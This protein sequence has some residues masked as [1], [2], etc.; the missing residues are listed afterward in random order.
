MSRYRSEPPQEPV[1]MATAPA[2]NFHRSPSRSQSDSWRLFCWLNNPD[3]SGQNLRFGGDGR[4]S[5]IGCEV[6]K[7]EAWFSEFLGEEPS[8]HSSR[9]LGENSPYVSKFHEA[10]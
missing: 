1:S 2:A 4:M 3:D 7:H 8:G 6:G 10:R 9:N 5:R